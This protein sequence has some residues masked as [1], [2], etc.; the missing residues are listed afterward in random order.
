MDDGNQLIE[1]I[2]LQMIESTYLT[3]SSVYSVEYRRPVSSKAGWT[4]AAIPIASM[5]RAI[6][7][8]SITRAIA[9]ASKATAPAQFAEGAT[10]TA[11]A[12]AQAFEAAVAVAQAA[13]VVTV[14]AH[15]VRVC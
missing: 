3:L 8:A 7:V 15:D 2:T 11:V 9:I 14:V 13:I 5:T 12:R 6:A 10:A 1:E 4:T